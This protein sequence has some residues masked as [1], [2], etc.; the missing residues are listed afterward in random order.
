MMNLALG[1]LLITL[2][3]HSIE[4]DLDALVKV[5]SKGKVN[6]YNR[7]SLARGVFQ[8]TPIVLVEW[9]Q[10]HKEVIFHKEDLFDPKVSE[11]IARWYLSKRIPEMLEYYRKPITLKN[12]L[13]CWNAGIRAVVVDKP[14]PEE[15][16]E[17]IEKYE[18]A[19]NEK[20]KTSGN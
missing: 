2:P 3:T 9:N 17:F 15:T 4:I 5:E 1:I 20:Q 18:R 16:K 6:A 11:E 10:F 8:I 19:K 13:V 7:H 12:I 14:L